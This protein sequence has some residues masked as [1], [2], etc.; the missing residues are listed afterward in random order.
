MTGI[1]VLPVNVPVDLHLAADPVCPRSSAFAGYSSPTT[2]NGAR[3]CLFEYEQA[4]SPAP[5]TVPVPLTPENGV[6]PHRQVLAVHEYN[7]VIFYRRHYVSYEDF[8]YPVSFYV[9]GALYGSAQPTQSLCDDQWAKLPH[10]FHDLCKTIGLDFGDLK[11]SLIELDQLYQARGGAE[12]TSIYDYR[13][14]LTNLRH[15]DMATTFQVYLADQWPPNL[16]GDE[17]TIAPEGGT[18]SMYGGWVTLNVPA[19]AV[20]APTTVG[21]APTYLIRHPLPAGWSDFAFAN[22][23][24]FDPVALVQPITLT[25]KYD[26]KQ[27]PAGGDESALRLYLAMSSPREEVP[28]SVVDVVAHTVSAPIMALDRFVIEPQ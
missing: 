13:K 21:Y 11:Q 27:I 12:W 20:A 24:Y 1:D 23:Y 5:Q 26:P 8:V 4:T 6:D 10:L 14:I 16:I 3:V 28:G 7:H 2:P 17:A 22:L 25:L 18:I 15:A 9:T 19:G